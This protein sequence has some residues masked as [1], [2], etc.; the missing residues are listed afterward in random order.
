MIGVYKIQSIIKPERV[1]IGSSVNIEIRFRRHLFD[2]RNGN[3]RS[4]KL[5]HHFEKYGESDLRFSL[6][7]ECEKDELLLKEQKYIDIYNPWFNICKKAGNSLGIRFKV[8]TGRPSPRGMSNKHHS[9]ISKHKMS[10][11]MIKKW[12]DPEYRKK[13]GGKKGQPSCN[14]GK[15]LSDET[16]KKKSES[17][18]KYYE[19]FKAS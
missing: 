8:T 1:Y 15:K 13:A 5:Q 10:I 14:K 16:C 3:G 2:L 7:F 11:A 17:M 19:N 12:D 9:D 6:L 4:K 18:K